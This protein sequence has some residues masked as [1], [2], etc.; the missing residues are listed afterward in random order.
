MSEEAK[1]KE[2]T[3]DVIVKKLEFPDERGMLSI[4]AK[5][6]G[7]MALASEIVRLFKDQKGVNYV[8]MRMNSGDP[9]FGSFDVLIQRVAGITPAQKAGKFREALE[10]IAALDP[11]EEA[12]SVAV[13]L[14]KQALKDA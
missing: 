1:P 6:P 5:H 8:E 4:T 9:E 13:N 7:F 10:K 11:A 12:T 3:E 14:A 2:P